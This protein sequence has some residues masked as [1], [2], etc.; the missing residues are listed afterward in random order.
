MAPRINYREAA[1]EALQA[2]L[3][4]EQYVVATE[5]E[6]AIK[7]LVR[8]RASQLNGCAYCCDKHTQD[9]LE[10][11]EDQRRLHTLVAWRETPWFNPRERAALAWTEALTLLPQSH[12][13]DDVYAEV[14]AVFSPRE[15]VELTMLIVAINGWN[16]IGVGFRMEPS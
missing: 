10:H 9:A 14:A 2:M 8:L 13:P 6:H 16:R 7:E 12:A 4:L 11:G 3:G 15:Q 1:P 5:L